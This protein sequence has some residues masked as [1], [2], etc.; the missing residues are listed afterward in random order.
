MGTTK[1]RERSY[2]AKTKQQRTQRN[3]AKG[4]VEDNNTTSCP[5]SNGTN[6]VCD[7]REHRDSKYSRSRSAKSSM[8]CVHPGTTIGQTVSQRGTT[9]ISNAPR[10]RHAGVTS[11]QSEISMYRKV[12]TL[13]LYKSHGLRQLSSNLS[14]ILSCSN[15]TTRIQAHTI[16]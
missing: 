5:R 1:T 13:L 10:T 14:F 6:E 15:S 4:D 7:S 8:L 12:T 9:T 16:V 2:K 3:G 11:S